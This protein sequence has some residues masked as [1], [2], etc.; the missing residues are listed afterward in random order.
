MELVT[1]KEY[2]AHY[3]ISPPTVRR[4]E[5]AGIIK[6]A[7]KAGK[8]KLYDRHQ[9]PCV[10]SG[11]TQNDADLLDSVLPYMAGRFGCQAFTL[12]ELL[13]CPVALQL[14]AG[15]TPANVAMVLDR[16]AVTVVHYERTVSVS[17]CCV[18]MN[19]WQIVPAPAISGPSA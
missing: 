12:G 3:K 2:A 7:G 18:G 8:K 13:N 6:P 4:R 15:Y 10:P 19:T 9:P 16:A 1:Q 5:R 14:F 11:P 17:V